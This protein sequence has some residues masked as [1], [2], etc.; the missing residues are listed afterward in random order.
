MLNIP[1]STSLYT[2]RGIFRTL[3]NIQPLTIFAKHSF[4]DN[5]QSSKYFSDNSSWSFV[6]S[7]IHNSYFFPKSMF[8]NFKILFDKFTTVLYDKL[9]KKALFLYSLFCC[10]SLSSYLSRNQEVEIIL[11]ILLLR[12][13]ITSII[14]LII[15]RIWK[16][17]V[18]YYQ[19]PME[20]ICLLPLHI[21]Y[22]YYIVIHHGLSG[23]DKVSKNLLIVKVLPFFIIFFIKSCKCDLTDLS[24]I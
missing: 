23:L 18:D 17:P 10:S 4:L 6:I 7:L 8:Q 20:I 22:S 19:Y 2:C 24:P 5:W 15:C 16:S 9:F 13:C 1:K 3:P 21:I 12:I 11:N 14:K